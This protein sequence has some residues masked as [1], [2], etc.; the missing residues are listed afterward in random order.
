MLRENLSAVEA[1][2]KRERV[3]VVN[4]SEAS[5]T[6]EPE[7]EAVHPESVISKREKINPKSKSEDSKHPKAAAGKEKSLRD[8]F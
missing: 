2:I 5:P 6:P 8:F 3:V 4:G 1:E 7:K